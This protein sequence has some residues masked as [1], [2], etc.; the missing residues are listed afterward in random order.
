M[1]DEMRIFK[2]AATFSMDK[3]FCIIWQRDFHVVI[4]WWMV[5]DL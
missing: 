3:S 1:D 5:K 2:F 4:D